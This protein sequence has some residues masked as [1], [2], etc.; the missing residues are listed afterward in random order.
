[1]EGRSYRVSI[2]EPWS[3]SLESSD[4]RTP[5]DLQQMAGVWGVVAASMHRQQ[6]DKIPAIKGRLTPE[7]AGQLRELAGAYAEIAEKQ[8]EQ[9]AADRR[10][11]E[12]ISKAE[13]ELRGLLG[14]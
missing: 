8:F 1:M 12:Q 14:R 10:T 3:E 11:R 7:L 4:L 2:K 13:G 9:F 6:K 5:F